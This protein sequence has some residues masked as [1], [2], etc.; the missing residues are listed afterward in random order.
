[1]CDIAIPTMDFLECTYLN[2]EVQNGSTLRSDIF[3]SGNHGYGKYELVTFDRV[4]IPVMI[5]FSFKLL[6]YL[7]LELHVFF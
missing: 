7:F 3:K 6:Q 1:M 2:I 4:V 5:N